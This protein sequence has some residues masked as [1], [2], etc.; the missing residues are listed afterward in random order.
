MP[1][2][3]FWHGVVVGLVVRMI[4]GLWCSCDRVRSPAVAEVWLAGHRNCRGAGVRRRADGARGRRKTDLAELR[5]EFADHRAAA[6]ETA[7]LAARAE[8]TEEQHPRSSKTRTKTVAARAAA[9]RADAAGC[10]A[11]L[12]SDGFIAPTLTGAITR[13]NGVRA[14]PR[15]QDW[16]AQR[17][18][19]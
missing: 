17:C 10:P 13:R 1:P 15:A 18:R 2:L 9:G 16:S 19:C 7:R 5:S 12:P 3:G 4:F 14:T 11:S 8:R 6:A